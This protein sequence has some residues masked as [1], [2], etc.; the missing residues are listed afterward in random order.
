[1]CFSRRRVHFAS[2]LPPP[3]LTK[4]GFEIVVYLTYDHLGRIVEAANK[5]LHGG[6]LKLANRPNGGACVELALPASRNRTAEQQVES[7][8]QSV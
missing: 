8:K 5:E 3:R 6:K 4:L 2:T 7:L 1:M